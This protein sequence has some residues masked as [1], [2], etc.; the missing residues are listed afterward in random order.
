[1]TGA[2][3]GGGF[4]DAVTL[5]ATATYLI[6]FDPQG[7]FT[8][9]GTVNLYS[10]TDLTASPGSGTGYAAT[11][12][13]PGQNLRLSYSGTAGERISVNVTSVSL[14]GGIGSTSYAVTVLNPDGSQLS[15]TPFSAAGFVDAVTLPTTG[16]YIVLVDP[17]NSTVGSLT[18]TS[19]LFNDVTGSITPG[20]SAVSFSTST[21]GQNGRYTFS[22]TAGD[23][24]SLTTSSSPDLSQT[25]SILNPD[26]STLVSQFSNFGNAFIGTQSLAT[27]GTY[28][29]MIDPT[30]AA[31]G[32]STLTLYSVV[33]ITGSITADGT[34]VTPSI[35][36]PG[37]TATYT[38]SGTAGQKVSLN[39]TGSTIAGQPVVSIKNPNG[40]TLWSG[41]VNS[42]L[43]MDSTALGTTGTYSVTVVPQGTNTG[44]MTLK[45][46]TVVDGS[47]TIAPGGSAVM[48]TT[49]T[50]GQNYRL[51]FSGTATQKVSLALSSITLS[52]Y[53][54]SLL[55][56]DGTTQASVNCCLVFIVL[57]RRGNR[58]S[59]RG[60]TDRDGPGHVRR[61]VHLQ[62]H[63][64]RRGAHRVDQHRIGPR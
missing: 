56:P 33:N 2:G 49:S 36:T 59:L 16:T 1:M 50:P 18:A 39:I 32:G 22:G 25:F 52:N 13:T 44:S 14:S 26:G 46:Y 38:F 48:V 62:R 12:G 61:V 43:F 60:S 20:G 17:A 23:H 54:V 55:R 29:V 53:A 9:A 10:V 35:T 5:P 42:S 30:T 40:S 51:T 4:I 63:V 27:T 3:G 58:H 24:V 21:P 64:A 37:Q 47:G 28:T 6:L 15:T 31:T 45:L 57:P 11:F 19:Y 34:P 7:A 8:G 41:L